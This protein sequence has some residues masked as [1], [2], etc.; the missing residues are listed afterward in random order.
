MRIHSKF[1]YISIR[2]S[3]KHTQNMTVDEYKLIDYF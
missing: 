2:E 1:I 3:K